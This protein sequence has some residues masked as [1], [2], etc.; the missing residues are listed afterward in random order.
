M[1]VSFTGGTPFPS[2]KKYGN[3]FFFFFG[4]LHL[5]ANVDTAP[6]DDEYY[7]CTHSSCVY[8]YSNSVDFNVFTIHSSCRTINNLPVV[9]V[10]KY[11]PVYD[12]HLKNMYV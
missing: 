11:N 6:T 8:I 7:W 4:V 3:F 2:V 5:N 12:M 9:C 10:F 1:C